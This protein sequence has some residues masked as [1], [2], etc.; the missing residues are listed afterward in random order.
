MVLVFLVGAFVIF[1]SLTSPSQSTST[2]QPTSTN[3]ALALGVKGKIA[4]TV[5]GNSENFIYVMNADGTGATKLTS[6]GN[7]ECFPSWSPDGTKITFQRQESGVGIYVI[8]ADGS[9][10]H[11][12]S[13]TPGM[14][15]RSSWSPDGTQIIFSRVVKQSNDG[16]TPETALMVMNADG[17]NTRTILSNGTFNI[18]AHWSPSGSIVFMGGAGGKNQVF[19]VNPDGSNLKQLTFNSIAGDPNW[20]PDGT[21]ISFGSP[22]EG[23]GKLNIYTMKADGSDVKQITHFSP[24]Y[25]AGDTSW[26]PDG[27]YITF[28]WDV[29]GKYQSDPNVKA[30]V[31]IVPSDGSG[32]P[33]STGQACASVGCSPRWQP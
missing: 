23:G 27:K 19:T 31:W 6:C 10:L 32:E 3:N 24:P 17:S 28:E 20:S 9:N 5:K 2:L 11:R 15:V 7:S 30:E 4:Y 25:E 16:G 22:M 18:E 29:D 12:L 8:N 1:H 33:V 14:D 21:H 13:P 26:S